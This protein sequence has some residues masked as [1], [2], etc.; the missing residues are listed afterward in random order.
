VKGEE[1]RKDPAK[2]KNMVDRMDYK[3]MLE[4]T[5]HLMAT[6]DRPHK[7]LKDVEVTETSLK[8]FLEFFQE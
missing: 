6:S 7:R 4:Y 5:T 3:L 1:A 8:M 2:E